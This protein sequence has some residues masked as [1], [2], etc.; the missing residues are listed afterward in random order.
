MVII[1]LWNNGSQ[2]APLIIAGNGTAGATS[3]QLDNSQGIYVDTNLNLYVADC[4]NNRIQLFGVNS[5]NGTTV[6]GN[7]A[8][9]TPIL[10]NPY[11]ILT[12]GNEYLIPDV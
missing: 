9:G 12:D 4:N 3:V 7:G 5:S 1:Q 8:A 11:A 2:S 6:V 10:N